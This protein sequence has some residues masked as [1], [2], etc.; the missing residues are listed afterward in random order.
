MKSIIFAMLIGCSKKAETTTS[1]D[2]AK[3]TPSSED[4]VTVISVSNPGPKT[5]SGSIEIKAIVREADETTADNTTENT[6]ETE[7]SET[8]ESSS[9]KSDETT[10]D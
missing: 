7:G 6:S 5:N 10:T 9:E 8:T 3:A 2:N 1:T 4:E